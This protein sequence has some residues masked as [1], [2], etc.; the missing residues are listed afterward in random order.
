MYQLKEEMD[1]IYRRYYRDVY[2]FCLAMC[3][4]NESIA[5]EITQNSFFKAINSA[6][7]FRGDCRILTWLCQI[8]RN[9]Y[10]SYLRKEKRV[11]K[12]KDFEELTESFPDEKESMQSQMENREL[13]E[14]ISRILDGLEEPYGEV[15]RMRVLLEKEYTEIAASYGKTESWARVTYYRAKQKIVERINVN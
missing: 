7:S 12:K 11:L 15:F 5:E 1:V 8:A 2:H 4:Q 3:E 10:I 6:D 13:L 14:E 9:D